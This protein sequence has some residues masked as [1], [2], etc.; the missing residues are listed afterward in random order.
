[1]NTRD[2]SNGGDESIA[3][4]NESSPINFSARTECHYG[5]QEL[6]RHRQQFT[7]SDDLTVDDV[8][9]EID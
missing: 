4:S 8:N 6:Q 1:M 5:T 9:V 7:G 3:I 2:R